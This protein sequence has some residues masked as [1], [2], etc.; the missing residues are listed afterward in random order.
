MKYSEGEKVF[1]IENICVNFW[2]VLYW[3]GFVFVYEWVEKGYDV[4]IFNFDYVYMDMFYEVDLKECGYYWVM[5][6]I[7]ICK[8][9]G[10]VLE[11]L[12]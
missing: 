4:I 9:F 2:D 12:L 3:G 5:C 8:M 11:N 6:V 7:D 10:F 1:V